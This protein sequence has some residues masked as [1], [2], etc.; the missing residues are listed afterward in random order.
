MADNLHSTVV[1]WLKVILPLAALGLLSTLFL[2]SRRIDPEATL[3]FAEAELGER[4]RQPRLTAPIW[5]GV[6]EDGAAIRVIASEARPASGDLTSPTARD[7]VARIDLPGGGQAEIAA[8]LGRLDPDAGLLAVQGHVVITTSA[9][10]R[11]ETPELV[12]TLDRTRIESRGPV[13]ATGPMGRIEAQGML[14]SASGAA[15][16]HVLRFTGGVKLLYR[17]P[18]ATP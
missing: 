5:T 10:Y 11:M 8:D 18:E 6:T 16:G 14:L 3:P 7:L 15:G 12:A 4:L 17:A 1:A 2:V 13:V 9:G